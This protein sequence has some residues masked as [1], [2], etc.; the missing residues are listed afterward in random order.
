MWWRGKTFI[1]LFT[2][3][4]FLF[5]S[6]LFF[7]C[8]TFLQKCWNGKV[9]NELRLA[10]KANLAKTKCLQIC[11]QQEEQNANGGR[12]EKSW[13]VIKKKERNSHFLQNSHQN[14]RGLRSTDWKSTQLCSVELNKDVGKGLPANYNWLSLQSWGDTPWYAE[15]TCWRTIG[16]FVNYLWGVLENLE[17]VTKYSKCV[18]FYLLTNL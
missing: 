3:S 15:G 6:F 5:F 14:K 18:S 1:Y 10:R 2:F 13:Q 17:G 12:M 11:Q 9:E 4:L 7:L 8:N 16:T